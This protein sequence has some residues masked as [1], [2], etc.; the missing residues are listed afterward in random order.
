LVQSVELLEEFRNQL[1][2]GARQVQREERLHARSAIVLKK[3]YLPLASGWIRLDPTDN[4]PQW[5]EALVYAK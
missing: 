3:A 2:N 1:Q 5:P 4:P